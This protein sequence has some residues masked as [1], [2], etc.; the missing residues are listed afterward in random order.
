MFWVV[1]TGRDELQ[2]STG[3]R[4]GV[5]S[6]ILQCTRQALKTKHCQTHGVNSASVDESWVGV[7]VMYT[8]SRDS[9][10]PPKTLRIYP[11]ARPV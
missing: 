7:R 10:P 1:K 5:L 8:E 3:E 9:I 2:V 11:N 6:N 4:P